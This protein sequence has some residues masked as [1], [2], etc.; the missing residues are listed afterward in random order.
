MKSIWSGM[1]KSKIGLNRAANDF[2]FQAARISNST[3]F[4]VSR[5]NLIVVILNK[6]EIKPYNKP[7]TI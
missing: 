3:V 1:N 4:V 6:S 5:N 2:A 7:S